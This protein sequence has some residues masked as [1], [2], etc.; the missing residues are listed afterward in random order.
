MK[1]SDLQTDE[2][3]SYYKNYINKAGSLDLMESLAE[4][5][6]E[7][8]AF[9]EAIPEKK[10]DF[11]YQE[12]KWTIKELL[13]HLIDTERVFAYRALRFAREDQAEL[14]GYDENSFAANS[15]ANKRTKA[16]LIQEYINLRKS[17]IDLFATFTNKMLLQKGIASNGNLSVR[18]I[19]FIFV[20]H[21]NHHI[22]VIKERYL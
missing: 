16:S 13:Q 14:P 18:A 11:A 6:L 20:G 5:F 7:T 2:Y 1:V 19:G 10:Y 4:G 3:H 15:N 9:F 17:S 8:K 12:G 22:E 21:E